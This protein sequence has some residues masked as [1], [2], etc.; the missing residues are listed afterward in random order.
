MFEKAVYLAG[1]ISGLDL[2][3]ATSWR[4]IAK[5]R[6][7][8]VGIKAVSPLRGKDFLESAGVLEGSYEDNPLSTQRGIMTRD[9]FDATKC[10]A[11]FVNL[12]GAQRVSIG[13]VMEMAWCFEAR[14]PLI[15][16]ME[17]EGN[18][19]D[20]PMVREAISYRLPTLD[21]ALAVT[22]TLFEPYL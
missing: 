5:E 9:H 18:L 1:P 12:L 7:E 2:N 4:N 10:G 11:V 3:G 16:A 15:V 19:H 13:T 17:D 21:A 22:M 6:L 8:S 14:V 20:H